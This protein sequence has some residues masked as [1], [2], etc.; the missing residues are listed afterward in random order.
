MAISKQFDEYLL[1]FK[2]LPLKVKIARVWAFLRGLRL[3][4]VLDTKGLIEAG[5]H[6]RISKENG[7]IHLMHFCKLYEDVRIVVAGNS[8]NKKA[9]LRIGANTNIGARSRINV[10]QSVSIGSHCS[11][12]WDCDIRDTCWHRVRFLDQQSRPISL[13]V[14]IEDNVWIGSHVIIERGVRIGSNSVVEA[15]SR[16]IK[17]IPPNS[18]AAGNPAK[19]IKG[20]AG[21]DRD[22]SVK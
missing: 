5:K 16:V 3:W 17:D 8:S 14:I 19:V 10:T 13:P 20:I 2:R 11:I 9:E 15:G 18:L 6:V 21:W 12:S 22:L 7:A 1:K 4:W